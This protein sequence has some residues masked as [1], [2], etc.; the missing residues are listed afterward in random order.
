MKLVIDISDEM[1]DWFDNGFPTEDD[2][3]KL[4]KKIRQ[5]TP[6]KEELEQ[7]KTE[8]RNKKD[9]YGRYPVCDNC[10]RIIDK[11]FD[12]IKGA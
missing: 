7:I 5:G 1:Y 8:I 2:Y 9:G 10:I 6:L 12:E 11:H 4:W 3:T